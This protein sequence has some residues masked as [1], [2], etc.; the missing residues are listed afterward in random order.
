MF[1]FPTHS[2]LSTIHRVRTRV[3]RIVKPDNRLLHV[4]SNQV[5]VGDAGQ[6]IDKVSKSV[7]QVFQ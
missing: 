2:D 6:F 7:F 1:C 4:M 3:G 5:A